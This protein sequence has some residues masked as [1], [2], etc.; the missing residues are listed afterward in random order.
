MN[1]SMSTLIKNED[2]KNLIINLKDVEE[3]LRSKI[4]DLN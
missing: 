1:K 2:A 3:E 4:G